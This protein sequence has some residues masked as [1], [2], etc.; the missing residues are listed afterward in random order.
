MQ[1]KLNIEACQ[2]MVSTNMAAKPDFG[3]QLSEVDLEAMF[4][5]GNI[6]LAST[7]RKIE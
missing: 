1:V 3:W 4:V 6:G 2:I 7:H 5:S